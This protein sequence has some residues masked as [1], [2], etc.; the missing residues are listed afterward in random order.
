MKVKFTR[1]HV[2]FYR[3]END[4]KFYGI[5]YAAGE[6]N[7][8]FYIKTWL[9]QRGFELI[10]KR[11]WKDGHLLDDK[12]QYLRA[13]KKSS[14]SPHICIYSGFFA[15]EGAEKPWNEG[16]VDLMLETDIFNCQPDCYDRIVKLGEQHGFEV[17][18]PHNK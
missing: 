9:N 4:P 17:S 2:T 3:E 10:K 1:G 13:N 11:A 7:L 6:S 16:E 8:L 15:I 14:K 5:R 18:F 12:Q